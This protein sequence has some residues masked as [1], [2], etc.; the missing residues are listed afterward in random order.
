MHDPKRERTFNHS[1][2]VS[3]TASDLKDPFV[4]HMRRQPCRELCQLSVNCGVH[5]I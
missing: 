5:L 1:M 4:K 2:G 3:E